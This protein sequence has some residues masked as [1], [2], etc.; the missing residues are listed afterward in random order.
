MPPDNTHAQELVGWFWQPDDDTEKLP[1]KLRLDPNGRMQLQV[2]N[3]AQSSAPFGPGFD[4]PLPDLPVP[5]HLGGIHARLNGVVSGK[6]VSGRTVTDAE[7]T[8]DDCHLLTLGSFQQPRNILLVVNRAYIGVALE[9]DQELHCKRATWTA[10]GIEGWLNPGGPTPSRYETFPPPPISVTADVEIEGAGN[11]K[12]TMGLLGGFSREK[13]NTYEIKES[14]YAA[15]TLERAIPWDKAR[16]SVYHVHRFLRF[17]LD[18]LCTVKQLTVE[19]NGLSVEVVERSMRRGDE[20]PARPG[21]VRL[22][23]LFT[24]DPKESGVVGDPAIV[25]R[26][27]LEIPRAAQGTL[28][29]LHGLMANSQFVDTQI[30]SACAAGELWF[31]QVLEAG[32]TPFLPL[33]ATA[34]N[35]VRCVLEQHGWDNVYS[36]PIQRILSGRSTGDKVRGAFDPIEREVLGLSPEEKCEVSRGLLRVRHP[37]S[38]GKVVVDENL[39]TLSRLLRKARALLKLRVLDYLGVDWRS[40]ARYNRTLQWEL[41]RSDHSWNGVPYPIYAGMS[42]LDASLA[43]LER[44]RELKTLKEIT[45]AIT[46]AGC[47][48]SSNNPTR[49]V[50]YHLTKHMKDGGPVERVRSRGTVHW[51]LLPGGRR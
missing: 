29:R 51:R 20:K 48:T 23:A 2:I 35:E 1:G 32:A 25:L 8:L 13:G 34:R 38:H 12:V 6:T 19:A 31:S 27:W 46:A 30:V 42:P 7:I 39:T 14:G 43:Y 26:R 40:V 10:E 45:D 41:G 22:D 28:L 33:P 21:Q 15:L 49:V 11:A 47:Q 18:R 5:W 36:G 3:Q 9:S 24:A 16:E 4:M 50:S 44:S 37:W 17:C